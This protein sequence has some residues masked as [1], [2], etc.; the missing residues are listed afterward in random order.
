MK[1]DCRNCGLYDPKD[2]RPVEARKTTKEPKIALVGEAPGE[3][4]YIRGRAFV[5][6]AGHVLD[7]IIKRQAPEKARNLGFHMTNVCLCRPLK[8]RTP[9]AS[10][11]NACRGRLLTELRGFDL[12][13][14]LG[15]TAW[16]ALTGSK[17]PLRDARGYPFWSKELGTRVYPTYHPAATFRNLDLMRDIISDFRHLEEVLELPPGP[18][19]EPWI[20]FSVLEVPSQIKRL[21]NHIRSIAPR[22]VA[23]DLE[24]TGLKPHEGHIT[25]IGICFEPNHA[26]LV[27]IHGEISPQLKEMLEDRRIPW[28]GHNSKFD[29]HW[30]LSAGVDCRFVADTMLMSYLLDERQGVHS[31]KMLARLHCGAGPYDEEIKRVGYEDAPPEVL[32]PYTAKDVHYTLDLW[33]Q[34]HPKIDAQGLLKTHDQVL[35]PASEVFAE[36][37]HHGIRVDIPYAQG[38][39][40]H[41]EPKIEEVKDRIVEAISEL[42]YD[43]MTNP[44]SPIQVQSL[45]FDH[46][47]W[48]SIDG[49]RTSNEATLRWLSARFD[50]PW[51]DDILEM[52]RLI[53]LKGTYIDGFLKEVDEKGYVHP[54]YLLHGTVTGRLSC[55]APAMQVIPGYGAG[56][57]ARQMIKRMFIPSDG[58]VLGEA[59]YSQLELRVA[60]WLSEDPQ[61]IEDLEGDIHTQAAVSAFHVP[62]EQVTKELRTHAKVINFGVMYGMGPQGLAD[63]IGCSVWEAG[64]YIRRWFNRYPYFRRWIEN[65]ENTVKAKRFQRSITGRLRRYPFLPSQFE[66][67]IRGWASNT[68]IQSMAS[69][70]CLLSLITLQQTF[71]PSGDASVL[72]QVHDSIGFEVVEH[73]C[74]RVVRFIKDVMENPPIP[75]HGVRFPVEVAIGPNWSDVKEV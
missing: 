33:R 59:D 69:D 35:M 4:E 36:I 19:E 45:I 24:T 65:Q 17:E 8:N 22:A 7:T 71:G 41:L 29:R 1:A 68:P 5:G 37:E 60:A 55:K 20:T 27:D 47:G 21:H 42:G 72:F 50:A 39:Q 62:E 38:I 25:V 67:K 12:I 54:N 26:Y 18:I 43:D 70:L 56:D 14:T 48:P 51:I 32:H 49:T 30:L 11:V 9:K 61:M 2:Y 6:P 52:R 46:L 34:F 53:K 57:N 40:E 73:E 31:L 63:Q 10:E 3:Q 23:L 66:H 16:K 15:G 58:F 44:N 64:E 13:V 75:D 28:V 74:A